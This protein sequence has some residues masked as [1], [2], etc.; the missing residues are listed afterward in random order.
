V[1]G[2]ASPEEDCAGKAG[3]RKS[4]DRRG[5]VQWGTLGSGMNE[6]FAVDGMD[7]GARSGMEPLRCD[8][9]GS[10]PV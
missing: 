6:R 10:R 1:L 5:V 7:R 4:D 3:A 2:A 8:G 9:A